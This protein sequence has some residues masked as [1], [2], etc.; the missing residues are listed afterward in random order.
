MNQYTY[1]EFVQL[2]LSKIVGITNEDDMNSIS[3]MRHLYD[4]G[5]T[6]EEAVEY[7]SCYVEVSP[8]MDEE[9]A[10]LKMNKILRQ[11]SDRTQ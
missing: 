7:C 11:V 9:T 8:D 3:E 10:L 5:F 2:V 1:E 6:V 4:R